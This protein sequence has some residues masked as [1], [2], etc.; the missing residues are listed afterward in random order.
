MQK[1]F[2][3]S[4]LFSIFLMISC[5]KESEKIRH[6]PIIIFEQPSEN[7]FSIGEEIP[8]KISVTHNEVL[9]NIKYY[10]FC[11]CSDDNYDSVNLIEWENIYELS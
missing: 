10:E 3:I 7:T 9:D 5:E 11:D 6:T 4:V 8:V 1:I 2:I